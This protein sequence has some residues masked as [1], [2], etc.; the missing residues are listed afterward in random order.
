MSG[1]PVKPVE[2]MEGNTMKSER[3]KRPKRAKLTDD[4]IREIWKLL[5]EGWFQHDIAA[6]LGINQGRI[7]EVN[8][9]KRGSHITGLRPA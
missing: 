6:R 5:C 1:A 9:G 4:V 8:T 2:N 7:S 3:P